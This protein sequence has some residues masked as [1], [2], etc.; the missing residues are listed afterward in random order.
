MVVGGYVNECVRWCVRQAR[1]S[2]WTRLLRVAKVPNLVGHTLDHANRRPKYE[3]QAE[4][5]DGGYLQNLRTARK[6]TSDQNF[7][8]PGLWP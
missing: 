7:A 2:S 4:D 1:Q 5:Q 6:M 3:S 8:N